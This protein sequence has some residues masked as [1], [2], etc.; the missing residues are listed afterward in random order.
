MVFAPVPDPVSP[1][2]RM[3]YRGAGLDHFD[4]RIAPLDV[5]RSWY[6]DA[7]RDHRVVDPAAM[8]LATVDGDGV[9]NARTVLLKGLDAAGFTFFTNLNSAKGRELGHSSVAALVFPW[10]PMFRQIR[11]RG[12]VEHLPRQD[13][14]RYF[15]SRPRDSQVAAWASMQSA[16]LERRDELVTRVREV[17]VQFEG[18]DVLPLPDFW[19]GMRLRP[20]EVELWVG[21]ESRL[22]DRWAWTTPDGAPAPLDD[23]GRWV[24]ARRQP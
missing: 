6:A 22:H 11:V 9:P 10:H 20:F 8:V 2:A 23:A 17:E 16:P 1:G 12:A 14:E 21:K 13:S 7:Q 24:G 19:G 15:Q 3:T 4:P 18:Q 5:L